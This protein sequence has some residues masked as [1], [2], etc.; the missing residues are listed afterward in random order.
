M[1]LAATHFTAKNTVSTTCLNQAVE[2]TG[3]DYDILQSWQA[4][5][6]EIGQLSSSWG[7]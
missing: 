5:R 2:D 6:S 7:A 3:L 1:G 4:S